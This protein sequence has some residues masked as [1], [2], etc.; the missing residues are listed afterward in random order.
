MKRI[1]TAFVSLLSGAVIYLLFRPTSLLG[2]SLLQALGLGEWTEQLR[3]NVSYVNPPEFVVYCLPN[4]LWSLSYILLVDRV[5]SSVPAWHKVL[6]ASVIPLLGVASELMQA[7]GWVRGTYDTADLICYS[8]PF[9]IYTLY[10]WLYQ[11]SKSSSV[12]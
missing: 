6:W 8:L 3:S 12:Q 11:T 2:F 10:L 9:I 4:G 5:F 7:A 1:V